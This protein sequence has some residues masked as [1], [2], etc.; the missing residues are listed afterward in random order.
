M[1]KL[2]ILFVD[3]ETSPILGFTFGLYETN[4]IHVVRNTH[5]MS[6]SWKWSD[7]NTIHV[8]SL[9]DYGLYKRDKYDDTELIKDLHALM[10]SAHV[11]V[12]H[13]GDKFDIKMANA[14]FIEKGLKPLYKQQSIDTLKLAK[15]R[16]KFTSNKL[17][18]LAK[19]AG[20]GSKKDTGGI[21]LWIDCLN[22]DKKAWKKMCNYNKHDV[23]LLEK[24]Y[25]WLEPWSELGYNL[26]VFNESSW[27]CPKCGSHNIT[28]KSSFRFTQTGKYQRYVCKACNREFQGK[29]NLLENKPKVK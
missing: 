26:N 2:R 17:T 13:N 21:Q 3:I 18:D 7:E 6:F 23:Y 10:E 27:S 12:A 8:H 5:M 15:K 19:Y 4:V 28:K 22:G 24:I 11:I 20:F 9:P 29:Q 1:N 25:H 16:F 14:R